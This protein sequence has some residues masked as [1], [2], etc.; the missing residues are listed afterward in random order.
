MSNPVLCQ[1]AT[2]YNTD[3]RTALAEDSLAK[4]IILALASGAKQHPKVP[5][6]ECTVN[7]NLLYVYGLLY[8]LDNETLYREI[9]YAHHDHPAAGHPVRAATYELVSRNYWWP[10]MRKTIA[11]YLNNCDTYARIK[12]VRHAL[13]GLIKP[14]Q[15][16]VTRWSSLSMDFITD[17]PE[18]GP[19]KFNSILVVVDHLTK[20]T[21]YIPTHETVTSE[22]VAR[23]YLYNIFRLHGLSASIVSD[24][25]TQF[26]S[27]FSR[28]L[29]KLVA[30]SQIL[31]TG[32]HPYTDGQTKRV[33]AILK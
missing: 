7:N 23:L 29:C 11:R 18:S 2:K 22:Q 25:G 26:T 3:I 1:T 13:Y 8:V 12:P 30:I 31:S 6:G 14:M 5:L 27:G 10:N 28:A 21:H 17:L 4:K 20:M 24:R 15:I 9:I 33:N 16:P 19:N 32:F